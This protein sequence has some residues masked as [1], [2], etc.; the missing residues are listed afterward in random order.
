MARRR[1]GALAYAG[2][3]EWTSDVAAGDWIRDRLESAWTLHHF[4]PTDFPAYARVFH[5]AY[6]ERPVG[7]AWPAEGDLDGWEQLQ[8][9][10][11]DVERIAWSDAA[12]AFGTEMHGAA[13]WHLVAQTDPPNESPIDADGWRYLAPQQGL[14][15]PDVLAGI[16]A[17][18]AAHTSTPD[19]GYAAIWEG[20][21]GLLGFLGTRGSNVGLSAAYAADAHHASMLR[22][23]YRDA[24]NNV[25]RKKTWH[26]GIL[27][28]EISR[29]PRLELPDRGHVLFRA[30]PTAW[31]DPSWPSNVPWHE[32]E[33][34]RSPSLI[35]P[36]DRAWVLVTEIDADSTIIAGAPDLIR[37]ICA[38]PDLEAHAIHSGDDIPLTA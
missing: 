23:S 24:F 37:A 34:T 22:E 25:F 1:G 17:H 7:A 30:A 29:G 8:G 27:D 31:A 14:I 33:H 12:A 9:R 10:E 13:A 11:V 5:P 32:G 3:M 2:R 15:E 36:A 35:W 16:G 28:D 38:D 18:L 6:R 26:P 21:G 20:W 4:V 19:D